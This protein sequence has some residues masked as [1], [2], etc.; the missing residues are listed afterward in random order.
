MIKLKSLIIE[1]QL[2][3][4]RGVWEGNK[5]YDSFYSPSKEFARQ[6]T[7]SGLDKEIKRAFIDTDMIYSATPELTR[8]TSDKDFD[9]DIPLATSLG[10]KALYV[11]EGPNEPPS[12]YVIDKTALSK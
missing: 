3:I 2:P 6:F 8:A 5:R 4:Y 11:N 12:I 1:S 7:Q 10:F 9:R